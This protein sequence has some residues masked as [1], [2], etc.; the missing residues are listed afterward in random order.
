MIPDD[1][2]RTAMA[3][4]FRSAVVCGLIAAVLLGMGCQRKMYDP[5]W[6]TRPYPARLHTT[7]VADMQVFREGA[8]IKVVNSTAHSYRDFD[9][10]V[11]QQFVRHVDAL[12]AGD[13]IT[14]SLWDFHDE[15]GNMFNAGGFFRSYEPSPVRL[16]EIEPQPG[17]KMTGLITIR[18]EEIRMKPD[19]QR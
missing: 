5:A 2:L 18:K 11:N 8:S 7:N 6:A 12:S 19:P 13:A 14:L 15:Y 3:K 16:V 17:Q 1:K 9:L 10:W 4:A